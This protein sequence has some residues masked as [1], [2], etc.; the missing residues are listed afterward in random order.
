MIDQQTNDGLIL[1]VDLGQNGS[2]VYAN[3][4]LNLLLPKLLKVGHPI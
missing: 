1:K 3:V 2:D 4:R